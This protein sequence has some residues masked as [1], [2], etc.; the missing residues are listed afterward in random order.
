MAW[1]P[2]SAAIPAGGT[3]RDVF[4]AEISAQKALI[5]DTIRD[6]NAHI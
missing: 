4:I 3:L 1:R 5:E 6:A 2:S